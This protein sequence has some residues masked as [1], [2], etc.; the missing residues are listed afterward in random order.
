[1]SIAVE[2]FNFAR[3]LF[4]SR[5]DAQNLFDNN[6][7]LTIVRIHVTIK[8]PTINNYAVLAMLTCCYC[9]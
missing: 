9:S 6:Y 8:I 4:S 7:L 1:M 5:N 2:R 3:A